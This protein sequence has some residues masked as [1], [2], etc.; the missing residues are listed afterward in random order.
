[1]NWICIRKCK[2]DS[3]CRKDVDCES[4]LLCDSKICT[5]TSGS[6]GGIL[7]GDGSRRPAESLG[8]GGG[9]FGI[10]GEEKDTDNDGIP[11]IWEIRNGLDLNDPSD[12][13]LDFDQDGIINIQEYSYGTNPNNADTDG[14]G[15]S[16]KQEIDRGTNPL[17]LEDKS[18]VGFGTLFFI[19]MILV[20]LAGGSYLVYNHV[21][22]NMQQRSFEVNER[23]P[24]FSPAYKPTQQVPRKPLVKTKVEDVVKERRKEKEAEREKLLEAFDNKSPKSKEGKHLI[25]IAKDRQDIEKNMPGKSKDVFS[26]LKSISKKER[27]SKKK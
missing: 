6:R 27:D 24:D 11:D 5:D 17:V 19:I 12:S 21:N 8:G 25:S 9:E 13:N 23:L 18:G 3:S 26:K 22:K 7:L 1:L 4:G 16:D 2:V 14:D 20:V 15:I 10:S